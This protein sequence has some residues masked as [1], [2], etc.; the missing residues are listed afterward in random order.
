MSGAVAVQI[1]DLRTI[2]KVTEIMVQSGLP[3]ISEQML[4][5]LGAKEGERFKKA[6]VAVA[7]N[8]DVGDQNKN[9]IYQVCG[10]LT[11]PIQSALASLGF[12]SV[13]PEVLIEIG[14]AAAQEFRG[15]IALAMKGDATA[16]NYLQTTIASHS[17]APA[18]PAGKNL[19]E[20]QQPKPSA[21]PQRQATSAGAP[22]H[23]TTRSAQTDYKPRSQPGAEATTGSN[24]KRDF[25]SVHFYGNKSAHCF[26]ASEK[27]GLHSI[28]LDAGNLLPGQRKV[29]WA[30]AIHLRFTERELY[31]IYALLIGLRQEVKFDAH[32]PMHDKSF[33]MKRQDTGFYAACSAKEMGMRGV[34]FAADEGVRLMTL[35]VRQCLRNHPEHSAESL[36]RMIRSVMGPLRIAA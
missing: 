29:D 4:I 2:K 7:N 1:G 8:G 15:K 28:N 9:Y 27:D 6:L 10:L 30:N 19:R 17:A 32:G 33:Q 26:S 20:V 34:P 11:G 16:K 22:V 18:T 5:A 3:T 23:D 35:V 31:S 12:G 24:D 13:P 21:A 25:F 36:D 14:K